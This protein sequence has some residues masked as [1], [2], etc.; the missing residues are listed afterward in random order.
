MSRPVL[1]G[2][3]TEELER[4]VVFSS[5]CVGCDHVP[6]REMGKGA[7]LGLYVSLKND[8]FVPCVLSV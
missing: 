3:V 5:S 6:W 4:E 7:L 1:W 8:V 2:L